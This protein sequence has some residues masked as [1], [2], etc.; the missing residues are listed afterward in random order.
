MAQELETLAVALVAE[1]D[2]FKGGLDSAD[3]IA[4]GWASK[5]GGAVGGLVTGAVMVGAT[6]AAA[7][8]ISIGTAAFD[9]SSQVDTAAA[10]IAASLGVP[11]AEA[12]KFADVARQVYGNNFAD[13]VL[14]AADAV[15]QIAKQMNLAAEDPAL[16]TMTENAFRLRDVFG[17]EVGESVDAAKTL[18]ENFGLS[19][20]EAFDMLAAGYQSG[21]DRS[22]D[23]LDTIGEYSV[24]FASGGASA[25]SFFNLLESGL[26][27]GMLGTDKAADAFKEFR[28]RIQDG[29][30][31]T[32]Q[33]LE[34]IG[35]N[36][37]FVLGK[38]ASGQTTAAQVFDLVIKKLGE[39]ND[40][41]VQMQ[42]GVGLLGTQ[43]EDLGTRVT[44][45]LNLYSG[46][47]S[48]VEGSVTSLD[49]KYETFGSAVEGI[50]RRLVVSISPFTD[51]LLDLVNDA[52]P[53]VMEAFDAFDAAIAPTMEGIGSTINT[54]VTFV[55]GLFARFKTSVDDDALGP[56]QYW[57]AWAD[58]NLPMVETLFN[59][60]LSAIQGFW[61]LFGDDIM[62]IVD[63]TFANVMLIIDTVMRTIGDLITVALQLLTGD[64]E[65]AFGTLEGIATRFMDT[66]VEVVGN[67]ID[68]II[69]AV[70][71]I[72]WIELGRNIIQGMID[73]IVAMSSALWDAAREVSQNLWDNMT[74]WWQT[75]SPSKKAE[76]GLGEPIG[77]GT[78]GIE[79]GLQS[80]MGRVDGAMAGLFNNMGSMTP[81]GAGAGVGRGGDTFH[82]YL[83]G[84]AT[85]EDGRNI[86]RGIEDEKRA[87]G[88][89]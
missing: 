17:V 33:S 14:D 66:I 29:S 7:A 34:A 60:I 32:A 41:T 82:I 15:E 26:E 51:K 79:G 58:K 83:S 56:L 25:T 44:S 86:V 47:F 68:S 73:G 64:W 48:N 38:L 59:N 13:S 30:D 2:E 6:A 19:G 31:L 52:M 84:S 63:N 4:K 43:F 42:S 55:N 39:T 45:G 49:K 37:E 88:M 67:Q 16:K 78:I 3:N 70:T 40:S 53:A 11:T 76:T 77:Q 87:R 50:W 36:S 72:D 89:A 71:A 80:V 24:Q 27:G 57:Q 62:R 18:M 46:A 69:T 5:L 1:T 81:A 65:G 9:V 85:V 35:I 61:A 22:G 28:V 23:F 10:D 54:V 20:Q 21:L 8:V 75:G 12:E 74:G